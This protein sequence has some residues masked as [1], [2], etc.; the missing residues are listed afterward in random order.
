[1]YAKKYW[2]K[3]CIDWKEFYCQC[4]EFLDFNAEDCCTRDDFFQKCHPSKIDAYDFLQS[5]EE[6]DELIINM[7]SPKDAELIEDKCKEIYEQAYCDAIDECEE[8]GIW[9]W[10]EDEQY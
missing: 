10:S 3:D 7:A 8:E 1:M 9:D 6:F 4:K 5:Q 2:N